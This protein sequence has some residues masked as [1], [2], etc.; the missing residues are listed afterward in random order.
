LRIAIKQEY[1]FQGGTVGPK[2]FSISSGIFRHSSKL[3]QAVMIP[4]TGTIAVNILC[5]LVCAWKLLEHHDN[6]RLWLHGC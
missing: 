6:L 2:E 4:P 3:R 1:N 5:P